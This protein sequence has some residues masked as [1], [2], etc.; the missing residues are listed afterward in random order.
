LKKG[1]IAEALRNAARSEEIAPGAVQTELALGD[2]KAASGQR[3]DALAAYERARMT[4]ATME[5]E[6]REVWGKVLEEKVGKVR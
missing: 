6:G 4:I 5:P 3:A 1:D 2:A